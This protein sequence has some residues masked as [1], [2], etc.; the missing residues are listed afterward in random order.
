MSSSRAISGAQRRRAGAPEP[1]QRGPS[2]SINSSQVFSQQG[3]KV[4]NNVNI[5]NG[6]IA[7]QQASLSQAQMMQ[8]QAAMKQQILKQ[9]QQQLIL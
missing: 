8:Q 2:T 4:M 1:P 3:A 6:K 9:Q 7:G 5:P